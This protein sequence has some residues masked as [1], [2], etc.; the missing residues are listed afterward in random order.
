MKQT[1]T[2]L[3]GAALLFASAANATSIVGSAGAGWQIWTLTDLNQD[4]TPYWDHTSSD[5]SQKNVGYCLTGTGNCDMAPPIPG[6]IPYWGQASGAYD[7]NIYWTSSGLNES[8]ALRIE[9][10]GLAGSNQFG[11][12]DTTAPGVLHPIFTGPDSTGAA[13][14]FLPSPSFGLYLQADGIIFRTQ[15][16]TGADP[17]NQH[18]AV[19]HQPNSEVFWLGLED[20]PFVRSD[21]DYN[22][23]VVR[24]ETTPEPATFLIMGTVL[25]LAGGLRQIRHRRRARGI[26]SAFAVVF[27]ICSICHTA[28]ATMITVNTPGD[29]S[30]NSLP[31][32]AEAVLNIGADTLTITLRNLE[33]DPTGVV[34]NISG[35]GF[36]LQN[37]G[38]PLTFNSGTL[39][40]SA[41]LE[42]TVSYGGTYADGSS[43]ATGWGLD[44]ESVQSWSGLWVHLLG[45]GTAP[46]HTIIGG[47]AATNIYV[48]ANASIAG[49]HQH[50]VST[51]NP[52][53]AGDVVFNLSIPG[54]TPD[55]QLLGSTFWFNTALG[56]TVNGQTPIPE[57]NCFI[58]VGLGLLLF[59]K[60]VRRSLTR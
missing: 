11:W 18:L 14:I 16:G 20:L 1:I 40:S 49:N 8:A 39:T 28:S 59:A 24:I 46:Q 27:A 36:V 37:P 26:G 7:P 38:S 21:R 13:T 52:F 12:Y 41:G 30:L 60:G 32:N 4:G 47:P 50:P 15:S 53:L 44:G 51:H 31:V 42:R 57:P 10:A 35:F 2:I 48:N 19:F 33:D 25:L 22:D 54:L 17:G 34:Q 5:G 45:T 43:V 3:F 9:I 6:S 29:S 58:L 23:M 56:S 55:A